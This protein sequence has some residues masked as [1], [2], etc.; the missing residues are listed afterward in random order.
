MRLVFLG[1]PELAVPS[2]EAL[3]AAGHDVCRVISQPDRPR[4][5]GHRVAIT[6]VHDAAQRL[7]LPVS[8]PSKIKDPAF[9]EELRALAPEAFVLVAYGRLIPD[10]LL[11][12]APDRW[13]NMHPSLLPLYRGPAPIQGA[14]L[15]GDDTT[16][17]TTIRLQSEMD[18]GDILLQWETAIDPEETAGAL[19]DRLAVLGADCLVETVAGLAAGTLTP[20]AQDHA[21]AT[22]TQ[23]LTKA[24]GVLDFREPAAALR[25]RIR[26][27]TPWPG[28]TAAL[29]DV[30]LKVL[31]ADV[32]EAP[33]GSPPGTVIAADADGIVV[34][35]GQGGLCIREVQRAGKKPMTA[36][37]FL[38]GTAVR[39]GAQFTLPD[40]A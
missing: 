4:D 22:F 39:P 3:V 24:D 23:K 31:H 21:Q 8:Q 6:P 14:L 26:A 18:A 2:L 37:A 34:A 30:S 10:A 12:L 28:A 38:R 27:V 33:A 32:V 5:R 13:L 17:V 16:G 36:A 15:N 20:R 1:T 35:T 40:P 25:H 11:E 9:A 7:G 29:P 19:H